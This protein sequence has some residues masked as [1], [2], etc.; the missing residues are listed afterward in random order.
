[1]S[2]RLNDRNSMAFSMENRSPLLGNDLV[3]YVFSI[4]TENFIKNGI[5]K[6]MLRESMHKISSPKI[7]NR[8]N[9]SGRPGN[10]R[11]FIFDDMYLTFKNYI[12]NANLSKIGINK[13]KLLNALISEKSN[14]KKNSI[15]TKDE[16]HKYNFYFRIFCYLSWKKI[17]FK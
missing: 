13:N 16:S 3:D 14:K 17:N 5:S 7:L 9:K 8:I 10:D 2:L 4:K 12:K 11:N 15:L 6:F 1:M